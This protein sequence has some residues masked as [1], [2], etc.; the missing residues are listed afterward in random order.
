MEDFKA[1]ELFLNL[2]YIRID[3]SD[4][5]ILIEIKLEKLEISKINTIKKLIV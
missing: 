2:D 4:D 5:I 1:D 3:I